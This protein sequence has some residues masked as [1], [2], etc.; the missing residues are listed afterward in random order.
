LA[1]CLGLSFTTIAVYVTLLVTPILCQ[2]TPTTIS[3]SSQLGQPA[4][5]NQDF[6][7]TF[8]PS[9]FASD[10]SATST[11]I[12]T[13][14]PLPT[15]LTFDSTARTFSGR[16]ESQDLGTTR[17]GV[18]ASSV[19]GGTI[20]SDTFDL[21]VTNRPGNISLSLPIEQQLTSNDSAITSA[22]PYDA[23][24]IYH[25]GVRVP[26]NWSFSLGFQ[27][28]TFANPNGAKVYY[29]ANMAD[30]S[31]LP[32]WLY[33]NNGSVTFD[34]V[35]PSLSKT[36]VFQVVL[37]GADVVGFQDISQS[38][39]I[40]IS[41][42]NLTTVPV[43]ARAAFNV[44]ADGRPV[45]ASINVADIHNWLVDSKTLEQDDIASFDLD[46][47]AS[48]IDGLS[49]D[50]AKSR[51]DGSVSKDMA[52]KRV[53]VP[54][55]L[56][57]K[58]GDILNSTLD[59]AF[60][61][62]IWKQ[63]QLP[64][65]ILTPGQDYEVDI[66]D[67]LKN[68]D[69]AF[70][71]TY[72]VDPDRA[73]AHV[74]V[75]GSKDHVIS[76]NFPTDIDY[77]AVTVHL[78]AVDRETKAVSTADIMLS[79][80]GHGTEP[81]TMAAKK[82]LPKT[83]VIAIATISALAGIIVLFGLILLCLRRS[84][85][86][87]SEKHGIAHYAGSSEVELDDPEKADYIK[88]SPAA[89]Y[90]KKMSGSNVSMA[91][92]HGSISTAA[93]PNS[94][95]VLPHLSSGLPQQSPKPSI[96]ERL[97]PFAKP[98]PRS[99]VKI[100]KPI[101]TPS[102]NN[103]AFQAQL[104]HAVDQAG[105]VRRDE[106]TDSDFTESIHSTVRSD[107]QAGHHDEVESHHSE[108]TR[109]AGRSQRSTWESNESYHWTD[110][111]RLAREVNPEDTTDGCSNRTSGLSAWNEREYEPE[112]NEEYED[113]HVQ[114]MT[115]PPTEIDHDQYTVDE[116]HVNDQNAHTNEPE[117]AVISIDNIYFP[118]ESDLASSSLVSSDS[119]RI[120][121]AV[122]QTAARYDPRHTLDSPVTVI[123]SP[124]SDQTAR[125]MAT[126]VVVAHSRLVDFGNQKTVQV[127]PEYNVQR[128]IS[129]MATIHNS[130]SDQSSV[131]ARYESPAESSTVYGGRESRMSVHESRSSTPSDDSQ[132]TPRQHDFSHDSRL[133][134]PASPLPSLPVGPVEPRASRQLTQRILLGVAEPFHFYPP[135]TGSNT[136]STKPIT[137]A[138]AEYSA[139]LE[140]PGPTSVQLGP[141]PR[142][143][144]FED[145][146]VWGLPTEHDRGTWQIRI[147]EKFHGAER[148]VGRF[149]LEVG[150]LFDARGLVADRQVEGDRT[151]RVAT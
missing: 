38:F 71:L 44:T 61:D 42:R 69:E 151:R 108:E 45:N 140:I 124:A 8:S 88:S 91:G 116:S 146:E 43:T 53:S 51:L 101:I 134:S 142:W 73:A 127:V 1:H 89:Q 150:C 81:A 36:Q 77:N 107:S 34:G 7:F 128:N 130:Q 132:P 67:Q 103:A 92:T 41:P 26:P 137:K 145:M 83:A 29:S 22:Y 52:G 102:L 25:P 120:E 98:R 50:S 141:L 10:T 123:G 149:V 9:T 2:N 72:K 121:T 14:T 64:P 82:G 131:V 68:R 129:H 11:I 48:K 60:L 143:L 30:G 37:A 109:V 106:P 21:I 93:G 133:S 79:L 17:V 16:P 114:D 46:L 112:V 144:R 59:I 62:S 87:K 119:D 55:G 126:P 24:S 33:F 12:Y 95:V 15:W 118:T 35:A 40:T 54:I 5:A 104:A 147:V 70:D 148:I 115:R 66:R 125:N 18:T 84:R 90:A 80:T 78:F 110:P 57:H 56:V 49:F 97:N 96:I 138:G 47:S 100:S 94:R 76:G 32:D 74:R 65:S 39:N 111:D 63:D 23:G 13:A 27:S 75:D 136:T 105:I 6:S 135:L 117:G 85:R 3:L 4:R 58:S 28:W 113:S 139:H 122:I 20:G 19:Q 86:D 99:R 31:P